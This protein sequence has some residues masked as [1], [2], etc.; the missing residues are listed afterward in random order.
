MSSGSFE[1]CFTEFGVDLGIQLDENV[2][3]I[4]KMEIVNSCGFDY[5]HGILFQI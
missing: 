2:R 3:S 4:R 1:T 5:Y